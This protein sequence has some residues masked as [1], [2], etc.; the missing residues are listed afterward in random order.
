MVDDT[1]W[2][3]PRLAAAHHAP[4]FRKKWSRLGELAQEVDPRPLR[5]REPACTGE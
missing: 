2:T 3:D 1:P 5:G 4:Q